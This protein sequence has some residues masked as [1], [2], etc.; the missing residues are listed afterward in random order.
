[1]VATALLD[2]TRL[3]AFFVL[4]PKSR[5]AAQRAVRA[6]RQGVKALAKHPHSGRPVEELPL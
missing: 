4:A 3:R 1:L 2:V 5:E 6:I